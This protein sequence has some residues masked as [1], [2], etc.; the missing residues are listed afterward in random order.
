M[1]DGMLNG[2]VGDGDVM[3]GLDWGE[4]SDGV[5]SVVRS[6]VCSCQKKPN[7]SSNIETLSWLSLLPDLHIPNPIIEL[8]FE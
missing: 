4:D 2:S 6:R 3:M 5:S 8:G 1:W 7:E